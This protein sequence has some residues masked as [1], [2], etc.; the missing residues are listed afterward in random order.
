MNLFTPATRDID[1]RDYQVVSVEKLRSGMR[2]GLRR[3]ILV[4][5]TAFGKTECAAWIIQQSMDKGARAWF[6]VDRVTLINQTSRRF[7]QYGIDH[8]VIQAQHPLTDPSKQ[9]QIASAQTIA[10]RSFD[11]YPDLIVVDEAHCQYQAVLDL[12]ERAGSAKVI[13]LTATPFAAGMAENWDGIVNGATVN[14]LLAQKYLTPLK[15]KACVTPD[16]R[17]AKKKFTGEYDE[18]DAGQRGVT[19]IGDVVQ[20][21]VEQTRKFFGGPVKTIVFSPSVKHGEELC[22]QFAEAG[23]NFQQISYL[24]A[25]DDDRQ[26]KIDEF[27]KPDSSIDGLVSCAVLTKGFDVPDVM[28]GI[29]CRPYAKSF[30]SH[31]Q[32][33][34]RVM[35]IAPGKEFG[36]WLDHSG[37]CISFADDTAWLYEHGVDSLSDAQKK[38]SEAREPKERVKAKHFCG[39]CGLQLEPS[40]LSCHACGWE[41]P[42]RGEIQTVEGELIDLEVSIKSAFQ[43]RQGLRAECL[44]DPRAVWNAALAYCFA[45]GRRGPDAS[46]KWAYGIWAGIYPG[47]K[48]PRG[49]YDTNCDTAKVRPDE[50]SL[51]EREVKRFRKN[52]SRRAA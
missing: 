41:R 36:L 27:S 45:N 49:L 44:G 35:R 17:G 34:G 5:P 38:D 31:I 40:D 3:V 26:A 21:W 14:Q 4:A 25:S 1:L 6:I 8:G 37:N 46:R 33:L 48:L 39:E 32:E 18:E 42:K 12:I 52:S 16:M 20:T 24:D 2:E 15:I 51:V 10:R 23:F 19:I 28:C 50:W 22:R 43:P 7:A 30:S 11:S 47:S 13:G 29:S 9:I